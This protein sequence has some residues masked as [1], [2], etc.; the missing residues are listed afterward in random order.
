M[1]KPNRIAQIYGYTVCLVA[2]IVALISLTAILNA[3]FQRANPLQADRFG[4][5]ALTSF[6]AYK[7]TQYRDPMRYNPNEATRRDTLPDSV[8]RP[9][10][11]ALVA[12]RILTTRYQTG[13]TLTTSAILLL[14]AIGLFVFH[15]RWV[16]RLNG[17]ATSGGG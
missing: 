3:M 10:Y 5:V 11:D 4:S 2:L 14:V 13:K 1:D 12:D 15:W 9:R 17:A 16:R 7:A 6:E 8:L